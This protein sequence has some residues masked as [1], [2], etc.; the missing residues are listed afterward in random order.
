VYAVAVAPNGDV[1]A[2]TKKGVVRIG[3]EAKTK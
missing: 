2:G 1:W 3:V